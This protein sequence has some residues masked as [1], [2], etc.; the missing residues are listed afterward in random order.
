MK[1]SLLIGLLI[2]GVVLGGCE[3]TDQTV[4]VEQEESVGVES[5]EVQGEFYGDLTLKGYIELEE[6]EE[7]GTGKP[8][9]YAF[10]IFEDPKNESFIKY[11]EDSKG[12]SFLGENK[13]GLGCYEESKKRIYSVNYGAEDQADNVLENENFEKISK[14][15]KGNMV[16]LKVTK[17]MPPMGGGAPSCYSHFRN[18]EIVDLN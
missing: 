7:M 13:L 5:V 8:F 4:E 14:S 9:T 16:T 11:L 17:P 6:M 10:F 2:L 1:K 18:F 3:K 15:N 12:N